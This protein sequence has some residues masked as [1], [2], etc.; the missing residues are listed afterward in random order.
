MKVGGHTLV[1]YNNKLYVIGGYYED[2]G[3]SDKV[4]EGTLRDNKITWIEKIEL[5]RRIVKKSLVYHR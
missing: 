5:N 2:L 1:T 4:W 3:Y